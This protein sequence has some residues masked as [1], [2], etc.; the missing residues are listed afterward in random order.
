MK[1]WAS[2]E[3]VVIPIVWRHLVVAVS[4]QLHGMQ[5]GTWDSRLWD[6]AYWYR[7]G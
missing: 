7:E 5:G 2:I 6:L 4:N 3:V 1:A